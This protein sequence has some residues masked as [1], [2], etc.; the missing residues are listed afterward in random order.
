MD[1]GQKVGKGPVE[2]GVIG[3][4]CRRYAADLHHKQYR[5]LMATVGTT[6][7]A[8]RCSTGMLVV[9]TFVLL[10]FFVRITQLPGFQGSRAGMRWYSVTHDIPDGLFY[11][12]VGCARCR[13]ENLESSRGSRLT[14]T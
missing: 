6:E 1:D 12:H 11:H 7:L 5:A 10:E 4:R 13:D 14:E 9:S 3:Q 8:Y 2:G